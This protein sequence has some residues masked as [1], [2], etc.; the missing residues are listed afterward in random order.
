M[1]LR[2]A[3][4]PGPFPDTLAKDAYLSWRA[5]A[6]STAAAV[7]KAA[8]GAAPEAVANS[9]DAG[10]A[11][12][13]AA[14]P[15]GRPDK[16][17]AALEVALLGGLRPQAAVVVTDPRAGVRPLLPAGYGSGFEIGV[18]GGGFLVLQR[19]PCHSG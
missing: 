8:V 19:Q 14:A 18:C 3:A 12:Q 6:A 17:P 1:R 7:A 11:A 4:C 13:L 5:L 15:R 10:A 2:A 16:Y 9:D